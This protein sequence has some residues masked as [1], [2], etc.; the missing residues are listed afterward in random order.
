[1]NSFPEQCQP[2]RASEA[3]LD[4]TPRDGSE[5]VLWRRANSFLQDRQMMTEAGEAANGN[6]R[7]VLCLHERRVL[8]PCSLRFFCGSGAGSQ[9]SAPFGDVMSNCQSLPSAFGLRHP[10]LGFL[11]LTSRCGTWQQGI[12]LLFQLVPFQRRPCKAW[13]SWFRGFC[14]ACQVGSGRL[15]QVFWERRGPMEMCRTRNGIKWLAGMIF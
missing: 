2:W 15:F 8:A 1:M 3:A 5:A 6:I 9:P 11:I 12:R 4:L 7:P 13:S 14:A 10:R